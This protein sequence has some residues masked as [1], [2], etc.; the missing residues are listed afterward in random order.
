ML[1]TAR[2]GICCCAP[3]RRASTEG[4]G[5]SESMVMPKPSVMESPKA[6]MVAA[7]SSA[8]TSMPA[9]HR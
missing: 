4:H 7:L 2:G 8:S 3:S 1:I 5:M 9:S 6:T